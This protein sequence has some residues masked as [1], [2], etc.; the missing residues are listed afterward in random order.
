MMIA[1]VDNVRDLRLTWS[2]IRRW[3]L[4]SMISNT[5]NSKSVSWIER[6]SSDR[7]F[8][9]LILESIDLVQCV[10]EGR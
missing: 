9:E 10:D 4:S 2:D 1:V 8:G 5:A 6:I 3:S 7:F